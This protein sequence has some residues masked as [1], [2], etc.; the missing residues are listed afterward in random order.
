V[1]ARQTPPIHKENLMAE[2]LT[3]REFAG[4]LTA[5]TV[6]SGAALAADPEKKPEESEEKAKP[7]AAVDPIDLI[8]DLVQQQYPH[9]RL[10]ET[11][12]DEVR[13][14]VRQN[15]G[16]SRVLSSFPLTNANEPGFVF[17]AWRADLA[18]G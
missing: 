5:G 16:R 8:L 14:D 6:L 1:Q 3:R 9:E 2:P 10:N 13:T 7:A 11:A 15:L 12:L 18:G 4:L 17:S